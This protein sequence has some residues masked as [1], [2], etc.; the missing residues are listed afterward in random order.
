MELVSDIFRKRNNILK[1]RNT[2]KDFKSIN[3]IE[4]ASLKSP[5]EFKSFIYTE[6]ILS[7]TKYTYQQI[8]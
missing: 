7:K 3:F 6:P 2:I 8:I 4:H 1:C 5:Q